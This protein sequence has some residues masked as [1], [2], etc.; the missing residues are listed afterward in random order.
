MEPFA[1][2]LELLS[3]SDTTSTTAP[4]SPVVVDPP[5]D[6]LCIM[7][8]VMPSPQATCPERT[9]RQIGKVTGRFFEASLIGASIFHFFL[10]EAGRPRGPL[11]GPL[12]PRA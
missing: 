11:R 10:P 5:A 9:R 8:D 4:P 2:I 7:G 6:P 1:T 12:Y 3:P